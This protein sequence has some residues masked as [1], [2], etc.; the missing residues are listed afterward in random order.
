MSLVT[1]GLVDPGTDSSMLLAGYAQSLPVLPLTSSFVTGGFG[2]D[3]T[4][5]LLLRRW[6]SP[7]KGLVQV[8]PAGQVYQDFL[9]LPP[10]GGAAS[11]VAGAS[12]AVQNLDVWQLPL[13]DD[14]GYPIVPFSDG[15]YEILTGGDTARQSFTSNIWSATQIPGFY[16]AFITYSN[17]VGPS[18]VLPVPPRSQTVGQPIAPFDLTPYVSSVERDPLTF[19]VTP[20]FTL[21]AGISLSSAGVLTGTPTVIASTLMS[22]RATDLPGES[23]DFTFNFLVSTSNAFVLSGGQHAQN[24]VSYG[25]IDLEGPVQQIVPFPRVRSRSIQWVDAVRMAEGADFQQKRFY[26][27]YQFGGGEQRRIFV[28]PV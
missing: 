27:V 10:S 25:Q 17:D 19:S 1:R 12:P 20:G 15:T 22:I 26:P 9:T 24:A 23:I 4:P 6:F 13:V 11:V 7:Y 5:A 16:G 8:P 21:P 28:E 2:L 3:S 14:Q 18:Q